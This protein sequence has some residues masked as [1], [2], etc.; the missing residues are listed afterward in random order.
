VPDTVGEVTLR[1]VPDG[2]PLKRTVT[3]TVRPVNNLVVAR[4]PHNAPYAPSTIVLR[5]VD[6]HVIKQIAVPPDM[7]ARGGC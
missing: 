7:P 6:G 1:F 4:E 3:T 5:G 2:T